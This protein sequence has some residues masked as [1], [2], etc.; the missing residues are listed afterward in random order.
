MRL[1]GNDFAINWVKEGCLIIV[2][3]AGIKNDVELPL[4]NILIAIFWII[5]CSDMAGNIDF[6]ETNANP[7]ILF[8]TSV[9]KSLAIDKECGNFES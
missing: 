5:Y 1:I 4:G 7:D 9:E 6:C 3:V 2:E 8:V